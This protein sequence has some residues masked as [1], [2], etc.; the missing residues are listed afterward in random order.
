MTHTRRLI[1]K[2]GAGLL[3]TGFSCGSYARFL[4]PGGSIALDRYR[5][6]PKGLKPWLRLRLVALADLHC[7][8]AHMPL[9]RVNEIVDI[10]HALQPDVIVLLGDYI[11]GRRRMVHEISPAMWAKALGRL[12]APLGVH[13]ILGNHEYWDDAVVQRRGYGETV[14]Q[15]ALEDAG[16]PVLNN[17]ALRIK[18]DGAPFWVAGL[19][20]QLALKIGH[21]RQRGGL[22][23]GLD[24]LSGTLAQAS[25]GAPV[26][27]LAHEPDIFASLPDTPHTANL[28]L[29]L[30][31][32]T[33][34]GQINILGWR[35]IIPSQFGS[36]FA[37]GRIT[38]E[39][40]DLIVSAGLGTSGP[41]VRLGVPP[42]VV[43]VDLGA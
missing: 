10:T 23:R 25:D 28:A 22:Y 33:H 24:D 11:T 18:K 35:P 5:L 15:K 8:S 34:G 6:S 36:R 32:H 9:S 14:G 4:E 30:S 19:A 43:I 12:N 7:G 27:L 16:L 26:I 20:D 3:F 37:H 2:V 41:P 17:Q 42:E 21:E 1:L 31:G 29:T 13:V 38:E 40:R 39:G